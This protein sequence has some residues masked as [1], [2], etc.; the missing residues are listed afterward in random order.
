MKI[1]TILGGPRKRGNTAEVL[2]AFEALARREHEVERIN[3]TDHRVSGCLGCDGCQPAGAGS[4]KT[5][6]GHRL[7]EPGCGQRDDAGKLLDRITSADVVVY[8]CPVYSW[9]YPAQLKALI[10][11]HYCLV[12]SKDGEVV[13]AL[14]A[15]KPAALLVTCGSDGSGN[16]DLIEVMFRRQIAYCRAT[17]AGTYVVDNATTPAEIGPRAQETAQRMA[18]D[19]LSA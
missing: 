1:L 5:R 4:A 7:D 6:N 18:R 3:I 8:A 19:L 2:G 9:S 13:S 11:R 16:A 15:G 10:D 14:M 17:Y 12:K